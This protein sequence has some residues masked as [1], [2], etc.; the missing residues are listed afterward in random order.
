MWRT[1]DDILGYAQHITHGQTANPPKREVLH[2][3]PKWGSLPLHAMRIL[4]L[5]PHRLAF[6][7]FAFATAYASLTPCSNPALTLSN[8]SNNASKTH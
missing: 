1:P 7:A 4:R 8:C 2:I 5:T 3:L 6:V